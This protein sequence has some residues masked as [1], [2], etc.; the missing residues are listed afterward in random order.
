ML[1]TIALLSKYKITKKC[2]KNLIN[3]KMKKKIEKLIEKLIK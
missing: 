1:G 3:I 2:F